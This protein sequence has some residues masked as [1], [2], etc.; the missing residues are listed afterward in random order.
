MKNTKKGLEQM[1][2]KHPMF[3]DR[4]K[5]SIMKMSNVNTP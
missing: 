2:I 4:L 5:V 1:L 3:L